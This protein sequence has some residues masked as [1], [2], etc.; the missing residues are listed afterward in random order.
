VEKIRL[1]Y[2]HRNLI[3]GGRDGVLCI[4]EVK[5]K[6]PKIRKDGRELPSVVYSDELLIPCAERDKC[7][8]DLRILKESISK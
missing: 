4:F 3:S 7:K 1:S 8:D 2:D 5:D 6:E